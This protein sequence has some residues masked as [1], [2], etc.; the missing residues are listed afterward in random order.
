MIG[1]GT[2]VF[3]Q[4]DVLTVALGHLLALAIGI[5]A[6]ASVSGAHFNPAVTIGLAAGGYFRWRDVPGYV[7][8]QL[9]GGIAGAALVVAAYAPY[10]LDLGL[11]ATR[12]ADQIATTTALY[13][14]AIGAF[15]LVLAVMAFA[16]NSKTPRGLAGLGIG[17]ALASGILM[18]LPA[19]GASFN[20]ARTLGPETVL[21]LAGDGSS[22]AWKDIYVYALGPIIGAAI[23]VL[24]Y[25]WIAGLTPTEDVVEDTDED[26][27]E[28]LDDIADDT[29]T[30]PTPA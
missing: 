5:Y 29:A 12:I 8:A 1:A 20:F 17:G 3:A 2:A 16:V 10:A 30:E 9:L 4:G 23:A 13:I 19:T 6:F 21:Q 7:I 27:D 22:E 28:A 25:G 15:I 24:I 26:V 11:G 18:F 14:E